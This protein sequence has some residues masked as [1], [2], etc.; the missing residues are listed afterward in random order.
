MVA[1][2]RSDKV[3]RGRARGILALPLSLLW[4]LVAIRTSAQEGGLLVENCPEAFRCSED[5]LEI[6][7]ENGTSTYEGPV[8]AG[9]EF[10]I[11]VVLDTV[12]PGIVG[13]SLAVK[14]DSSVLSIVSEAVTTAGTIVD[15]GNPD[16]VLGDTSFQVT[17]I[18]EGGF[19]SATVLSFFEPLSLPVQRN[20]LCHAAYR[21]KAP[22][23][24]TVVRFVDGQISP[25]GGPPVANNL[26]IFPFPD[27]VKSWKP[28]LR[29]GLI[30]TADCAEVCDDLFDNDGDGLVDC[31]DPDCQSDPAC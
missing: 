2:R 1:R 14:H 20:V 24:C 25:D 30:R 16:N 31:E 15:P 18:T 21:F 10:P 19:F 12:S 6:V 27:D 8:E 3:R 28:R 22:T 4:L 11:R 29:Q 23:A 7:F 26:S 13:Y 5:T 9:V 17:Q